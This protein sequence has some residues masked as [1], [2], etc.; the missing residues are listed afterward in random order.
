VHPELGERDAHFGFALLLPEGG[1]QE[2]HDLFSPELRVGQRRPRY[3]GKA[4][5]TLVVLWKPLICPTS[6]AISP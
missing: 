4:S 3:F 5:T 2:R 1:R 6:S